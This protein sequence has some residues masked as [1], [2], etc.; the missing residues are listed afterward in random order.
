MFKRFSQ[1]SVLNEFYKTF[2]KLAVR[3]LSDLNTKTLH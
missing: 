2:K 3:A 1:I